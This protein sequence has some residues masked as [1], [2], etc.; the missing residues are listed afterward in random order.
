MPCLRMSGL[1]THKRSFSARV[2]QQ[3]QGSIVV[4]TCGICGWRARLSDLSHAHRVIAYGLQMDN[5]VSL[6]NRDNVII[7]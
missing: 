1:R 4:C 5:N 7:I 2:E 3:E 6:I